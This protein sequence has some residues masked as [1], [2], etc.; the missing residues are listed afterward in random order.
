MAVSDVRELFKDKDK[1]TKTS[2]VSD[3][4]DLFVTEEDIQNLYSV[5]QNRY[6]T[7]LNKTN[8]FYKTTNNYYTN[9]DAS[10]YGL[11]ASNA[12]KTKATESSTW[13]Q[14]EADSLEGFLNQYSRYFDSDALSKFRTAL[15]DI[16]NTG[17]S[18]LKQADDDISY[19]SQFKDEGEY[20]DY[21]FGN[22]YDGKSY[23]DVLKALESASGTEKDWLSKNSQWYMSSQEAQAEIDE[24]SKYKSDKQAIATELNNLRSQLTNAYARA[25]YGSKVKEMVDSDSRVIK[26]TEQ[27]GDYDKTGTANRIAELTEIR[28]QATKREEDKEFLSTYLPS[29]LNPETTMPDFSEYVEK[30]KA[31]GIGKGEWDGPFVR[32]YESDIVA[33]KE[34]KITASGD[35]FYQKFINSMSDDQYKNYVYLLGKYGKEKAD[36][37]LRVIEPDVEEEEGKR[38]KE[39]ADAQVLDN[40]FHAFANLERFAG[41]IGSIFSNEAK[42]TSA[43]QIADQLLGSEKTGLE[44]VMWDLDGNIAYM[45]PSMLAGKATSVLLGP[46]GYGVMGAQ[47]A[48]RVG[49]A[50]LTALSS[51]GAG[52]Q[53]M[54]N[55]GYSKSQATMYGLLSGAS[56]A[57]LEYALSG[58]GKFTGA[59]TEKVATSIAKGLNSAAAKFVIEMGG[60]FT[61]EALQEVLSPFFKQIATG[62]KADDIDWGQ[63]AYAGMLGALSAGTLNGVRAV[64]NRIG[65]LRTARQIKGNE[66]KIVK[67][68]EIGN[69]Y[70]ADTLANK[71]ASKVTDKTG[72]WKIAN[73]IH[74]MKGTLTEQNKADIKNQLVR[75]GMV[76][77][78]AE[79]IA[80]WL[81]KAVDG[82]LFTE[83]QRKALDNNPVISRVFKKVI[84]DQNSTVNQRLQALMD[85]QGTGGQ[86]GIDYSA[87]AKSQS[88]EAITDRINFRNAE[89]AKKTAV[90]KQKYGIGRNGLGS[91]SYN[92]MLDGMVTDVKKAMSKGKVSESG[93]TTDATTGNPINIKKVKDAQA[94]LY[95]LA[96]GSTISSK[97]VEYSDDDT[98]I[99][100]ETV[101]DRGYDTATA[102]AVINGLKASNG[103]S[104]TQYL[105]G[106][107]EAIE[108]GKVGYPMDKISTDGFYADLSDSMKKFAYNLGKD[109]AKKETE[110]AQAKV[111]GAKGKVDTAREGKV[112]IS[113]KKGLTDRQKVSLETIGKMVADITHNKVYIFESVE[114]TINGKKVRV[115]AEDVAGRK[116]GT[117]APNGFYNKATGEIY[118][119]LYAGE[120]GEGTILWTAAHELTHFIKAWSPTKF[121]VLADFLV[122]EYGEK[123]VNVR[124]LVHKK[125]ANSKMKELTYDEAFEEVVAD[126]MQTMFTDTDIASKVEKLKNTDK[127][128]WNKIKQFFRDLYKRITEA[129]KGLDA[130]TEEARLVREMGDSIKKLSDLFAEALVDAGN[131]YA[132]ADI[133]AVA[134]G[135]QF[136]ERNKITLGMTDTERARILAQKKVVA[137]VY[138]GEAE[139]LIEANKE[140]LES[141]KIGLVKAALVRIGEEFDVFADYDIRDIGV[142]ITLSKSNLKESVSKDVSPVQLA[143]LLPVLKSAVENAIGIESHSNRYFYDNTTVLFENMLGGYVDGK[144]FVPIRFGLK[145]S[146]AGK[147]TLYVIVSQQKIEMEKIKAEIVKTSRSQNVKANI[148]PSA[149]AYSIPQ[150]IPFVNSKDLLRYLPDDMLTEEQKKTKA[151]GIAETIKTT[152][153]KNDKKYKEF[154]ESGNLRAAQAMV[155]A[156]AKAHGYTIAAHHGSRHIFREFSREKRGTNTRTETSKRW[157]FAADKETANSYYPYGVMKEIQKQHPDW[158]WADPEKLKEKGKLYDLFLKFDNPLVVDVADYDYASHRER[159]DAWM[160]FVQQAEEN[161]ND[162]IILLNAL[163]NQLKT[164]ARES[165]V[166]M[167]M[168]S[169]QAKSAD[170]ITYDENDEVIP[171]SQRFDSEKNDFYFSE[172]NTDSTGA[173]LTEAQIEFFKDSQ[174]RD[175]NGNLLVVRHGTDADFHIFD[176]AKAGKNGK[177]E[178]YGFY[179]SDDPEITSKYGAIQKEVYLNITKPLYKNK[180]TI[181]RAELTKLANAL[182]DFN[183]ETYKDDGLTWQDS[184]ISNYVMTYEMSRTAAVREFINIIWNAN[185]N[186][187]DLVFEMAVA[188]GKTYDSA[189]MQDFYRVLTESIGYDGIIAEWSHADGTSNVYVT[190]SSEQAKYTT[191]TEPTSNPDLRYSERNTDTYSRISDMQVEVNRL[192]E[193]IKELEKTDGFKTA[194]KNLGEAID[195]GDIERGMKAYKKWSVDSGYDDMVRRRDALRTDLDKLRKEYNESVASEAIEKEK[196]AIAKSGLNEAEYFRKSAVKEFGYTPYFYDAGYLLPNGKLLNFSGEK[197]KHFG[198]RGQDH[199]AIGIV[200]AN[201][202]GG[203]AMLKFMSEGNIRVMAETPGLDISSV[204]EP[205]PEQ[206]SAIRKFVREYAKEQYLAVDITDE[207]GNVIGTYSYENSISADRVVNDIKYYFANGTMRAS[208]VVAD[209]HYSE[210]IL[211][212]SLFSGGGTLEAGLTYQM[213]D[214]QFGVEYDGKIASVYADNHGDHIQVGRVEDF[215]ISKYKDIFYLHASPVCHNFSKAK[216]GATELQMDIDSAKATAKHLETAM[217][218]VFTVENAPGYLKSQSLKIITD[219][220]TELGYKWDVDVYN[221]ADYGSATS[222][223]R[224]I[225]RAVREGELPAKPTKQ[226]RTNSWDKVTRDLWDTLPKSA[227]RPSFISAIENTPTLPIFDANGKVNVNKPLLILTTTNGHQVTYCWEGEICPTLT[228]K[229][230]EAKLVMPDGNIYAVTPEFMGRIQGLPNDYKYPKEKTR[231]FTIIGNGIPTHLTKA[232]VGGVLDSAYE[233]THDGEMLYSERNSNATDSRT[234]LANALESVA[235]ND[236]ERSWLKKYK[237]QIA[238][239]N[240]DQSELAKI[241]AKIKDAR[242]TKGADRSK[243]PALESKANILADRINKA[244]KRL[245]MLEASKPLQGVIDRERAKAYKLGMEKLAK[246]R[247]ERSESAELHYYRPR[248]EKIVSDLQ[249]RLEHPSAKT[250]IPEVFGATIAKVLSA[251]DFTTYDSDGNVR[252]GKANV[253]RAEA[254]ESLKA[255]ANQLGQN[256]IESEYGQL[257]IPPEMLEWITKIH[258]AFEATAQAQSDEYNINKMSA[259]ELKFVYKFLKVWQKAINN[260]GRYYTNASYDVT[261]DAKSTMEH[262]GKLPTEVNE[263]LQKATK[264]F[265]WDLAS[266]VTVF[267]RF[268]EGGKHVYNMLV[269]GQSKMAYNVQKILDFVEN[270]YT[271]KEA[272]EWQ[273][274]L[275]TVKIGGEEYKVTV[276]ML[277]GLHCLLKQEDSSR[278]ILE[279][280]GIRFADVKNNGKVK[281]FENIFFNEVDATA[282]ETALDA[283]PR[284][285]EVAEAMQKFM[286]ETGSAWGNEISMTRFGYHAFTTKGYYPIRTIKAGSE[287]EAQQKRA[288]IYAL[289][290]KSF[291]KERSEMA[292]NAVIVDGIFSVFNNHMAE[293]AL[294]NAWALP[295]IDTIKWFNYKE[296]QDLD[297]K[298]AEKSVHETLRLAYGSYADRYVRELLEAI[299]SQTDSGLSEEWG[300]INMRMVNRVAVAWNVRVALQQPFSIT[301]A[302]ELINP[303]YV[304]PLAGKAR[305]VAYAEMLENSGIAKWKSMGYYSVDVSRPLEVQ[306]KKNAKLADKFSEVGMKAAEDGDAFTWTAL[307][308]ACKKETAEKNPGL[309][310]EE[311]L[312]KT[313]ERFDDLVLRTQVVDSVLVKSPWLRSKSFWHK[314]T[315]AFMSEPVTS[316]NALL[317]VTDNFSRD[318]AI[319]GAKYAVRK[320]AKNIIRTTGVFILTQLVNALVTAPL[321]GLRDDDDYETYLEK[322][323]A[324]FKDNAFM[325]LLPTSMLPY[326]NDI[327]EYLKYGKTDRA[328]MAL[329]VGAVDLAKSIYDLFDPDKRSVF[330]IHSTFNSMLKVGSQLSGFAVSN[331]FRDALSAYNAV[332]GALG[333]GELKFQT[334]GDTHSEGYKRMYEAMLDGDEVRMGYLFGQILSNGKDED[335]VYN[336]ITKL[337]SEEVKSVDI[338]DEEATERLKKII[339]YLGK[340]DADGNPIT[341]NDIY[342]MIDKWHYTEANGSTEDYSK[343]DDV[344]SAME[345][346]DPLT[347]IAEHVE[348]LTEHYYTLAKAKAEEN[349]TTLSE[350]KAKKEA[351][352]KAESAVKSAITS[353]WKPKYKEAYKNK[354]EEEMKRIRYMLRDTKLYGSTTDLLNTVKGWLKD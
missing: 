178:G 20:Y 62:K 64:T 308:N 192:T 36:Q 275:V 348:R 235:Q 245:L 182:I 252:P 217:P 119:D 71:L 297:A 93:A 222:R 139:A 31:Q 328:D 101:L 176:F 50:G 332:A 203:K 224:V 135:T 74:E 28:G 288:N 22:K 7:L 32:G 216:H 94:K 159:A 136:S 207:N 179:F 303:K 273:E 255:L 280:G 118:I 262:V 185:D 174:V 123:G 326:A 169:S 16:K 21:Y 150:I 47:T 302:Y 219:K 43:V 333:Y 309:K 271:E 183:V 133:E 83:A 218:M 78:D 146:E 41:D 314:S 345:D 117:I 163:D 318:E 251:F 88:K 317:R 80:E 208:S 226:K 160:E 244:D 154:I 259:E 158:K 193:A 331:I 300:F 266:P 291:T 206:Y 298:T 157:F 129:Y 254:R 198:S 122:A 24:L 284:A 15:G 25:G 230:G 220:L 151:E 77:S 102:N 65:D 72:A 236:V 75:E 221:S 1:K 162:G 351:K 253:T 263:A 195:N 30:G 52:K 197:G 196:S 321:D 128:L 335:D 232:V 54:L 188:D 299:N 124:D 175:K 171:L 60:E 285:K 173:T 200:Y 153:D 19:W 29:A 261:S 276:D 165:T 92:A 329:I 177:A 191:N 170:T 310:G 9:R 33:A 307:W 274:K 312:A 311:L 34:G 268:G 234:L 126:S 132:N 2:G 10:V 108:Y 344:F 45:M 156:S 336:G 40:L 144:H 100:Y 349:G 338:T 187:Q 343:Y 44:K 66:T 6:N 211:M 57:G 51:F 292:N 202:S 56:E 305:D 73:V 98:A 264:T 323:L 84:I 270:A 181:S 237:E 272:R 313:A 59:F 337:I 229:C 86:A 131:T 214:K 13:L 295:V 353:Y 248:I 201:V 79:T 106:V 116:A 278:H 26:L 140:S 256:T 137:P 277:M 282:V 346:G 194:T 161:G 27:L 306:V 293:M 91:E 260:V 215:D 68:K 39:L 301:R 134:D 320:N 213:L 186:D 352:S 81:G 147:A 184:F 167:F 239:L 61:E 334:K 120:S 69:T 209:F 76:E 143:R 138:H 327:I 114:K 121:K 243:L 199:R 67:L 180:R 350:S 166:Y 115:L 283:F 5:V 99:L 104:V 155:V 247:K 294:Y 103:L 127:G 290:N 85:F 12:W 42:N 296:T 87:I 152:N 340:T 109:T 168:E 107:D 149:F 37:Y 324:E 4:R 233:Q 141:Q 341:D 287:Y 279:G 227:L 145:H 23:T 231:A 55:L 11:D 111:D 90:V 242:F 48:G 281:R 304:T 105:N 347:A 339:E 110:S 97:N 96:D 38:M 249:K 257:D 205:T 342:W 265:K 210:R 89:E 82:D 35:W 238:S 319:H 315:S 172:R 112:V 125:M 223:N 228:T 95:E 164:G 246:Y 58:A 189:S 258:D 14:Q 46:A 212:G 225:L 130:Q 289:L 8:A 325:N 269:K 142:E 330:K 53:E 241:R 49:Q 322:V 113:T 267:D 286:E 204:A 17:S 70:A 240:A 148:S 250:A 190:F 316:Y 18:I 63:V 354:N 3:V